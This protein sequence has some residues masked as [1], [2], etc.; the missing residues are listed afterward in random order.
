MSE[1]ASPVLPL[2][3][4]SH[5]GFVRVA[6]AG[7]LGMITLRADLSAA[8][9]AKAV[10][11]VAGV[12]VPAQ[13]RIETKDGRSA[14]WMSPDEVLLVVPRDEVAAALEQIAKAMAG[15]HHLA[16]DV[17]DARAVF[18]LEGAEAREVLA[19]LCPVDLHPGVFAPGELRRTRMAQIACAFWADDAGRFTI[20][21]FRSVARYAFDLL[22]LSAEPGS[23]PGL[24][25]A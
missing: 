24:Y 15:T 11:S 2:G 18:T 16:V 13:R 7:P 17:S 12:K 21:T 1:A 14:G 10:K 19:K 3:G 9:T 4:A 23:A 6:E 20:V 5:Q 22:S 25:R 8:K